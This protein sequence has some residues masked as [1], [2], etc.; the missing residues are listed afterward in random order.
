M[1]V[2]HSPTKLAEGSNTES[3][4]SV[5]E[6]PIDNPCPEA[7]DNDGEGPRR[8]NIDA[9]QVIRLP[10]FW[11]DNPVLWFAQ[12]EAAFVIH[13]IT[14]DESKFRYIILNADQSVLPF[15]ADL[16]TT[17]PERDRYQTL[18]DRICS[19]LGE[20][21]TT[22]IRKL[23]GSHE[24]GDQKPSIFLQRLRNLAPGQVTDEILKSIFLEQ[25][26]EN[27]RAILAV[28]EVQDLTRLAAAAD[29]VIE[30][31]KPA[32]TTIQ[33]IT[34]GQ[35]DTDN[36]K[37]L[38]EIAELRKQVKK[39]SVGDRYRRRSRSRGRP[40]SRGRPSNRGRSHHRQDSEDNAE[41]CYYHNR[42]GD[43][44]F[45]CTQPCTFNKPKAVEN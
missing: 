44:A 33:A 43:K 3:T 25:L 34:G 39:L 45:K 6:K 42:F 11:K 30:V 29:K 19:T 20:T 9:A 16:I 14:S 23:L 17:P 31:T 18:K 36:N 40:E 10:P 7:M 35:A 13:R 22:K 21:S 15:V 41:Y 24:L 4:T 37:V 12:A 32:S 1:P 2:K 5:E 28:S 8:A 26:P 27:V 38:Q